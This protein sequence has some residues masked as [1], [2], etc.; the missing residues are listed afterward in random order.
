MLIEFFVVVVRF[1]F[2]FLRGLF[3]LLLLFF[4]MTT[5]GV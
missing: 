4:K 2:L 5:T 1:L 3:V